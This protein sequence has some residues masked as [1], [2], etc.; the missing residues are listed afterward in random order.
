MYDIFDEGN[1]RGKHFHARKMVVPHEH[2][3]ADVSI[4]LSRQALA[5]ML[6]EKV[7]EDPS[8]FHARYERS[9]PLPVVEYGAD[10]FVLT[11][12]EYATA[13]REA[14]MRGVKHAQHYYITPPSSPQNAEDTRRGVGSR[15][16]SK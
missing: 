14:F 2:M 4:E 7:L 3:P 13:T 15:E 1:L 12:E 16:G 9:G 8:F 11:S 6:A 10:C 5:R